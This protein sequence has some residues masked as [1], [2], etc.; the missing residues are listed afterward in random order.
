MT[1]GLL[2][3]LGFFVFGVLFL[4]FESLCLFG[5]PNVKTTKKGLVV[6]VGLIYLI[7]SCFITVLV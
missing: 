4:P 7:L 3:G 5:W 2:I 1:K 6:N